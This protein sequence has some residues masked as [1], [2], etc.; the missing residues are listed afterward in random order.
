[1]NRELNIICEACNK[2][3]GDGDATYGNLWIR[4][5]DWIDYTQAYADWK[6]KY[7]TELDGGGQSVTGA[8]LIAHPETVAWRALHSTCDNGEDDLYSIPSSKLSTWADLVEWTA[9]L[10]EK[11]WLADTNWREHISGAARGSSSLIQP[12][13]PPVLHA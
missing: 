7:V 2:P 6:A 9:H 3:M 5:A 1:V 10:M 12:V 4:K 8:G 11:T 13:V